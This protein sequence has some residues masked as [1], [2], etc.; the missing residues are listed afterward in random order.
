MKGK[1]KCLR[2]NVK[3]RRKKELMKRSRKS[4][5][6]LNSC[7]RHDY[8]MEWDTQTS[9]ALSQMCDVQ[10][11]SATKQRLT[12]KSATL[13]ARS[14]VHVTVEFHAVLRVLRVDSLD[15]GF[16]VVNGVGRLNVQQDGFTRQ[17]HFT[18]HTQHQVQ[19]SFLLDVVVL[20]CSVSPL[21]LY[22]KFL[23]ISH[24]EN[25]SF[26]VLSLQFVK[27]IRMRFS[28]KFCK[29]RFASFNRKPLH[30]SSLLTFFELFYC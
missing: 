20:R 10:E 30:A 23:H 15:L 27:A 16:H 24:R 13:R 3:K 7:M 8:E 21:N 9:W 18:T 29:Q 6:T 14:R 1:E 5:R 4:E 2:M 19:S 11:M 12:T 22:P 17:L 28:P 26:E 25:G